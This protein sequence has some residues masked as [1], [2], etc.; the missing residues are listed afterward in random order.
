MQAAAV[1]GAELV[2]ILCLL[3]SSKWLVSPPRLL[4]LPLQHPLRDFPLRRFRIHAPRM[5]RVQADVE[6]KSSHLRVTTS[7]HVPV[8]GTTSSSR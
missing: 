6:N 1:D 4:N 3:P 7:L 2:R 5:N 8:M